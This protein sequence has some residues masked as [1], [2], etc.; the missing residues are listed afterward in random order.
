MNKEEIRKAYLQKMN[1]LTTGE[2]EDRSQAIAQIF[3]R[4][5]RLSEETIH[6]FLSIAKNNEINTYFIINKILKEFPKVKLA[7][8]KSDFSNGVITSYAY[9]EN[10][11]LKVNKLGIPEP[12]NGEIIVP[13]NFDI[14]L[15]PLLAFD[16]KGFRTGYGKGFYD[17]FL[18]KCKPGAKKIGLSMFPPIEHTDDL[19]EFDIPLDCCITPQEMI[20]F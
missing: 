18:A 10:T 2:V 20:T 7:V 5:F 1:A 8:P 14:I 11:K 9:D 12:A 6:L 4:E 19:N 3:F 17:R 15:I 13:E 16:K